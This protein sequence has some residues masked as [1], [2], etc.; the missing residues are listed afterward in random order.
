MPINVMV[1]V[2]VVVM[3]MVMVVILKSVHVFGIGL[4]GFGVEPL[5][6]VAGFSCWIVKRSV[7]ELTWIERGCVAFKQRCRGVEIAQSRP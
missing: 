1:V 2:M 5:L 4:K 6:N 7:K 3:V